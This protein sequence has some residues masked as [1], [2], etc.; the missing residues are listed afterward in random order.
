MVS[1]DEALR[2]LAHEAARCHAL[3]TSGDDSARDAHTVFC[4]WLPALCK[5]AGVAPMDDFQS[6]EFEAMVHRQLRALADQT[7]W[8][9]APEV[10]A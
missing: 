6:L 8:K 1:S 2:F 3:S 4:L 9:Q 10:P 5:L 7:Q